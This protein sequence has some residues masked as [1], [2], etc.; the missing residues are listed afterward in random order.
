[1]KNVSFGFDTLELSL[2]PVPALKRK[3]T[4]KI[5]N[6]L[7]QVGL[8]NLDHGIMLDY[9]RL[10]DH[11]VLMTHD[12]ITVTAQRSGEI[13]IETDDINSAKTKRVESL[14]SRFVTLVTKLAGRQISYEARMLLHKDVENNRLKSAIQLTLRRATYPHIRR[15]ISQ[16]IEVQGLTLMITKDT[17]LSLFGPKD[18]DYVTRIRFTTRAKPRGFVADAFSRGVFAQ[19][20]MAGIER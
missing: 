14:A 20:Q 16:K 17:Y 9:A 1:M 6:K 12:K 11:I 4:G 10:P 5:E 18:F 8:W 13:T 3:V 19:R 15:R 2:V 7:R